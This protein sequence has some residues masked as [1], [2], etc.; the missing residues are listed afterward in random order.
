MHFFL[1]EVLLVMSVVDVIKI[2]TDLVAS[3]AHQFLSMIIY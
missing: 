1:Q 3:I 2:A